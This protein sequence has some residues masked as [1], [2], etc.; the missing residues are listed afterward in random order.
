MIWSRRSVL[1]GGSAAILAG[2]APRSAWG[3]T[4]ADVVIIG[5][6]LAGLIAALRL[7]T[8]G[9]KVVVVE[10]E[11]RVGGR[12][13][14]LDDIQGK[15][16]AGGIQVGSGYR[17]LRETAG[18]LNI[19]LKQ[20]ANETRSALYR[21]NGETVD[22]ANWKD[23]PANLLKGMERDVLP[24]A[25]ASH[26]A[27]AMPVFP[28]IYDWLANDS[29]RYDVSY[30]SWLLAQGVSEEAE[31]LIRANFNGNGH[32]GM[33]LVHHMRSAAI[34]RAGSGP[35]FTIEGGSQRLPEAMARTLKATVRLN[36]PVASISESMAGV[37]IKLENGQTLSARHCICTI[38]FSALRSLRIDA[39]LPPALN[40]LIADL[41]Y[42]RA[43]FAYLGASDAFWKTDGYPP[44][45]WSDDPLLGRVF[46]LSDD[47]PMLKVWLSGPSADAL[48]AMDSESAAAAI[49]ARY[50]AARPSAK[51]KLRVLRLFSW[52]KERFAKGIYHHIG[53]GMR[54]DLAAISYGAAH[55]LRFA[56]EHLA[57]NA[58]GMEAALESGERAAQ[59]IIDRA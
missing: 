5:A 40:A 9:L 18:N 45:L 35:V 14:T 22:E 47:P 43:S 42:T 15:P 46:V 48:D 52:Q 21:I 1:G 49:I 39:K 25:L 37:Q 34:F 32:N 23:S 50:E 31:R 20:S 8:A 57:L 10:G 4:E 36:N 24:A 41:P 13:H 53:V 51:G 7:E 12:L 56:G 6:G 30:G 58:S 29:D 3:R 11:K 26:Y 28:T 2:A 27:R 17:L 16:E 54:R 59:A 33:S 38:P 44:T 55:R 19:R